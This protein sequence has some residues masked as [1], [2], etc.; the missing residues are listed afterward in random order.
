MNISA[1]DLARLGLL[2]LRGGTWNGEQIVPEEWTKKISSLN[3]PLE[4]MNPERTRNGKLGYG[5]LWWIFDGPEVTDTVYEGAYT[6]IGAGGQYLTVIP[7]LDMVVTHKNDRRQNRSSL[8][9]SQ[10]Y[11]ILDMI[12]SA[13]K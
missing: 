6:G 11:T 10:Y 8:S 5:Y 1:R 4:E 12:I 3:T 9:R 7:K 13:K 2:M